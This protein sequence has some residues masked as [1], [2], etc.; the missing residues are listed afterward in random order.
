MQK[1]QRAYKFYSYS[2]NYVKNAITRVL[3]E[4]SLKK[5]CK[6][7]NMPLATLYTK[8][9]GK[10]PWDA[11]KNLQTVLL[12]SKEDRLENRFLIKLDL[13]Y[14]CTLMM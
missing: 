4:E 1:H 12:E 13:V 10:V 8:L 9:K 2:L 6:E 5:I 3:K 11:K 14:L 7:Y